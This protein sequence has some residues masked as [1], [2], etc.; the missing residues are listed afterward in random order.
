MDDVVSATE[1]DA[2]PRLTEAHL[3][4]LASL[5]DTQ[6]IPIVVDVDLEAPSIVLPTAPGSA[7]GTGTAPTADTARPA[8][9]N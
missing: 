9:E 4:L 3:A 7:A 1:T 2:G 6:P 5:A 8:E